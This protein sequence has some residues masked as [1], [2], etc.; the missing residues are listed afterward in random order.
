MPISDGMLA[1]W[2]SSDKDLPGRYAREVAAELLN[3]RSVMRDGMV[4]FRKA[5]RKSK[6]KSK[7]IF[8]SVGTAY[9]LKPYGEGVVV[10][11]GKNFIQVLFTDGKIRKITQL[12][13][14]ESLKNVST[15]TEV[16]THENSD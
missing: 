5:D 14:L 6:N 3:L 7:T 4:G 12:E 1:Q 16:A 2:S 10:E 8:P 13:Y 15:E 11:L 9:F